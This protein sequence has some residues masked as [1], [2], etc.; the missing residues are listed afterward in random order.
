MDFEM[1]NM[2]HLMSAACT[3]HAAT[4]KSN[5]LSIARKAADFLAVHFENPTPEVARHGI[6]PSHLM[7]L[8]DLY[9]TTRDEKYLHLATKLLAM[10]DL[11]KNGDDD[12]QDRV[13]LKQQKQIVGHAVRATYLY[14]GAADIYAETGDPSLMPVLT[15]TW[16]DLVSHKL[17]ITGGCGA[18]FDGASPDGSAAQETITRVH[19][20][21][22]RNYQLPQSTAHNETCAAI[23]SVLWSWRMLQITDDAKFADLVEQ[24][25]FNSVLAGVSL[26]GTKF[27]Y[28]NTLRQLSPMPVDLRWDRRRVKFPPCFCCPPN[29]VRTVAQSANYAYLKS[30]RELWV[31]LY[32]GNTIETKLAGGALKLR[33]QTDYPW[34]GGIRFTFETA[35]A[36]SFTLNLRIPAWANNATIT[37][38]GI[39]VNDSIRPGTFHPLNRK[40]STDDVVELNLPMPVRLVESHPYIEET[41]NQLA[42][43]RGPIVYCLE[44]IDLPPDA[45]MLDVHLGSDADLVPATDPQL[46]GI[47]VLKGRATLIPRDP[48]FDEL[49][50]DAAVHHFRKIDLQLIPYFAWDNRGES[51]MTVWLPRQN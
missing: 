14:A 46:P 28:T 37:V 24:T 32:G 33:Q 45:G 8:I 3:H 26:D 1:Y 12:N 36:E 49:Y 9:R 4:G 23:G 31:T 44:S 10:R 38:N 7:G 35:P 27:F 25:L 42:V 11:V 43:V 13:P 47:T 17:F 29:V 51:E 41:R 16:Q 48:W 5:L 50:R 2:G 15:A 34:D 19:Q 20:S 30:D 39:R 21:F 18:L 6:C 22:G 40:W